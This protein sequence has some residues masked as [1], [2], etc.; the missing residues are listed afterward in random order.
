LYGSVYSLKSGIV[1]PPA[2]HFLFRIALTIWGLLCF[3]MIFLLLCRMS[4]NF[5]RD[6]IEHV[7]CFW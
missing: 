7:D 2:F 3:H 6:C 5:D 4:L 1:M